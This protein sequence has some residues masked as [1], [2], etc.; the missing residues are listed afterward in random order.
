MPIEKIS[1]EL[2]EYERYCGKAGYSPVDAVTPNWKHFSSSV[3]V[4]GYCEA[5]RLR[6]RPRTRGY[7]VMVRDNETNDLYWFH[8]DNLPELPA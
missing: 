3:T 4:V 6:I 1:P 7:A 2:F 8:A 5:S